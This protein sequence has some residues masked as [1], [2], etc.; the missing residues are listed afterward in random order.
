MQHLCDICELTVKFCIIISTESLYLGCG[1]CF[2]FRSISLSLVL[3]GLLPVVV[4]VSFPPQYEIEFLISR[5]GDMPYG[6]DPVAFIVLAHSC[7][8]TIVVAGTL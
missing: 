1:T 3:D 6:L 2:L 7:K 4:G 8:L 5:H